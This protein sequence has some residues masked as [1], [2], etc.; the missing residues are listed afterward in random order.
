MAKNSE[1]ETVDKFYA[2]YSSSED[3]DAWVRNFIAQASKLLIG[4][5]KQAKEIK[6][7]KNNLDVIYQ[8]IG[9]KKK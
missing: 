3:K 8:L 7:F 2:A 9:F 1:K 6:E 5:E 4:V